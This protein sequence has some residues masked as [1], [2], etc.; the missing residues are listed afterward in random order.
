MFKTLRLLRQK[1]LKWCFSEEEL[2]IK[3]FL[4]KYNPKESSVRLYDE[5]DDLKF[6]SSYETTGI[7]VKGKDLFL[8]TLQLFKTVPYIPHKI[9]TKSFTLECADNHI[10]VD[11]KGKKVQVKKLKAGDKVYTENGIEEILYSKK[12][13]KPK[14]NMY[15]FELLAAEPLYYTDGFL[16][17]NTTT[18]AIFLL[19]FTLFF[20]G[21]TVGLLANKGSLARE[22]LS[23]YQLAYENLPLWMQ[24]GVISWN[25][26]SVELEN[27][28][29]IIAASTSSSAARGYAFSLIY[30]D[31]IAFISHNVFED[32]FT[33]VFP[34]IS[35]GQE[36]RMIIT[37]TPLG[38]NHF[39]L[40]WEKAVKGLSRFVPFACNW[41][42]V[43]WRDEAWKKEQIDNSSK[44]D[45]E[46]EHEASFK[47]SSNTLIPG[48]ILG[49]IKIEEPTWVREDTARIYKKP[50]KG[51]KYVL[52][53]DTARGVK[54]DYSVFIVFDITTEVYDVVATFRDNTIE[55]LYFAASV[56]FYGRAYN[57]AHI[58]AEINDAGGDVVTS[59]W[60]EYE[61]PNIIKTEV[62]KSVKVQKIASSE[63]KEVRR[64]IYTSSSVKRKGCTSLRTLMEKA[65]LTFCDEEILA[66]ATHF[67]SKRNTWK[68]EEGYHDDLMMCM[69]LFAWL[70]TNYLFGDIIADR[71][72]SILKR[73]AE[74]EAQRLKNTHQIMSPEDVQI[75]S[76]TEWIMSNPDTFSEIDP[77]GDDYYRNL[78]HK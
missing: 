5:S 68:A 30:I 14:E 26:G 39:Y 69:V 44:E 18:S 27:H 36:S 70:A 28:S 17:H 23:R 59:L 11:S 6:V 47:G 41:R 75:I 24:Q 55:P 16:S 49:N 13:R 25:K 64:G 65:M 7:Y 32:F 22:I 53:C 37:S 78:F 51:H 66:E 43:P 42:D 74:E 1:I 77:Y 34:T 2:T 15:D 54:K 71:E 76:D 38:L 33:S 20:S 52:V 29:E 9:A 50:E 56:N 57:D 46:Q 62:D 40:M 31:E 48:S 72:E 73:K 58:L 67:V 10:L 35:S 3:E 12:L 4:E 61:Y 19:W 8:P 63:K 45:F 21:K 60:H